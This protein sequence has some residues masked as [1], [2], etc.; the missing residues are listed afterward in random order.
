MLEDADRDV[1]TVEFKFEHAADRRTPE[2]LDTQTPAATRG[3]ARCVVVLA[4]C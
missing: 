2:R 3:G 1:V 4:R